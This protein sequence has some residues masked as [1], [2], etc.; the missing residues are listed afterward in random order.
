MLCMGVLPPPVGT[1]FPLL[2]HVETPPHLISVRDPR[3][4]Y[5]GCPP[6][7]KTKR[8]P[9][10]Y[11]AWKDAGGITNKG[12][13][14]TIIQTT[15]ATKAARPTLRL[16]CAMR[17]SFSVLK[18]EEGAG[19]GRSYLVVIGYTSL[20]CKCQNKLRFYHLSERH[21]TLRREP[22]TGIQPADVNLSK[23]TQKGVYST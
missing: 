2:Q 13:R 6:S 22:G 12:T 17:T 16:A 15:P 11:T 7:H 4:T 8:P 10:T 20:W 9:P 19:A 1:F 14:Q 5:I 23:N 18:R 21:G 3:A